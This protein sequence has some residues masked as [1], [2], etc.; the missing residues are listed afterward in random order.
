[1]G[2]FKKEVVIRAKSDIEIDAA[3]TGVQSWLDVSYKAANGE[4]DFFAGMFDARDDKS[5]LIFHPAC[6]EK[7]ELDQLVI[8]IGGDKDNDE[9]SGTP[10]AVIDVAAVEKS[11]AELVEKHLS[12][13]Q[14]ASGKAN[15][16]FLALV[17]TKSNDFSTHAN[18]YLEQYRNEYTKAIAEIEGFKTLAEAKE[19]AIESKGQLHLDKIKMQMELATE[20]GRDIELDITHSGDIASTKLEQLNK[21]DKDYDTHVV[22]LQQQLSKEQVDR[23]AML[24]T[25]VHAGVADLKS[26]SQLAIETLKTTEETLTALRAE[27]QSTFEQNL[28]LSNEL[29]A[30]LTDLES[31][32]GRVT[33][34]LEEA[35]QK[36]Q[37]VSEE[38]ELVKQSAEEMAIDSVPVEEELA[39]DSTEVPI[40]TDEIMKM[41]EEAVSFRFE[42]MDAEVP[43]DNSAMV[44]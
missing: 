24:K 30:K 2:L 35:E 23:E 29:D 19:A 16:D 34:T 32:E 42:T 7:F 18:E 1:M 13:I 41:V 40:T 21:A 26:V 20:K 39:S 33:Q 5:Y 9:N 11:L 37:A 10:P 31:L 28:S 15:T 14:S 27:I 36:A 3:F 25:I 43:D 38:L 8:Q 12:E 17:E 6:E 44:I 22:M 4:D